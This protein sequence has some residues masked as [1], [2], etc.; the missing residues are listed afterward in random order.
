M[1]RL[2]TLLLA[3]LVLTAIAPAGAVGVTAQQNDCTFPVTLTDATGTEVTVDERPD[4]VTTL[5]P[6]AAQTMWEIGGKSQV[7]GVTE[8]ADYLD[9]A[10][11]RTSV[12]KT[13]GFGFSIERVIGTEPDIVLA[14]ATTAPDQVAT[15]RDAGLTVYLF[16]AATDTNDIAEKTTTIGRLTGNCEGAA[17]TNAWMT[18]NVEAAASVTDTRDTPSVL[19]PLGGGFVAN[20]NTFISAMIEASGGTNA[21][22]SVDVGE[23]Q[24]PQVSEEI[25]LQSDPEVLVVSS[26]SPSIA[27]QE[28]YASTTAGR[29]GESITV[30]ADYL[31]QPAPRSV[32][33]TV[34]TLT[35]AFHPSVDPPFVTRNSA[36]SASSE[37][38]ATAYRVADDTT[39]EFST[40]LYRGSELE[41]DGFVDEELVNIRLVTER[42]ATGVGSSTLVDQLQAG[43]DG[44][45]M[46]DTGELARSGNYIAVGQ[47][48]G[49]G[50]GFEVVTHTLNLS[51]DPTTVEESGAT[52]LGD[53]TVQSGESELA[54]DTN[55][56]GT[57]V[58]EVDS[59]TL[60][61]AELKRIFQQYEPTDEQLEAIGLS[62]TINGDYA[63]ADTDSYDADGQEAD[64]DDD[65][66]EQDGIAI[67]FEDEEDGELSFNEIDT[68]EYTFDV[69]HVATSAG[70][71]VNV[72]VA[73]RTDGE[74]N[75]DSSVYSTPQGDRVLLTAQLNR[76]DVATVQ[77]GEFSNVNYE[78]VAEIE[79]NGDGQVSFWYNTYEA[80]TDD[81]F[82]LTESSTNDGD[83][84]RWDAGA[85]PVGGD[86]TGAAPA[87]DSNTESYLAKSFAGGTLTTASYDLTLTIN[88][89]STDAG[90]LEVTER[91]TGES[92]T[93]TLAEEEAGTVADVEDL[94]TAAAEG[95]L[96]QDDTI[97][98]DQ[99][100]DGEVSTGDAVVHQIQVTGIYGAIET[101][102]ETGDAV[103]VTDLSN[104][105][106]ATGGEN[107]EGAG[108][109]LVLSQTDDTAEANADPLVLNLGASSDALTIIPDSENGSLYVIAEPGANLEFNRVSDSE[110]DDLTDGEAGNFDETVFD[111]DLVN[112]EYNDAFDVEFFIPEESGLASQDVSTT[113]SF[114]FVERDASFETNVDGE[115]A[116]APASEQTISGTTSIAAGSEITI[117]ARATGDNPFFKTADVTVGE[118]GDFSGTFDFSDTSN[119]TEFTVTI[120][121]EGF[122]DDAET[123]GVVSDAA[124][125]ETPTPTPE[126]ATDT[127]TSQRDRE[128]NTPTATPAPTTDT[129]VD[130]S[131]TATATETSG[132][133]PGFG[134]AVAI[135]ALVGAAL[136]ALRRNN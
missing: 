22:A 14:P 40:L 75:F 127:P 110:I 120:P 90:T 59:E 86:A 122:D 57:L 99:T 128:T 67:A 3:A 100:A 47:T 16:E 5:N 62:T 42:D 1:R 41:I 131:D 116:V 95:Y 130:G 63:D 108:A 133:Q 104:L 7:V 112:A 106:G 87:T 118:D 91:T 31:N 102:T 84:I 39:P 88:Q 64:D 17:R 38:P 21:L 55:R 46:L 60:D 109:E 8:F 15:L 37:S 77:I 73:E 119:M 85:S 97:A 25:I 11:E 96:T 43:G 48:T 23:T 56:A 10:S 80:T 70:D 129:P 72:T 125:M 132:S 111:G 51:V 2:L 30:N 121:S 126:P 117:R 92:Q 44:A 29:E 101:G 12:S 78:A 4:R 136:I 76:T 13:D 58:Y 45:A 18:A 93:W 49:N 6:S 82:V 28:P 65:P 69:S 66:V 32:V 35:T 115:I 105:L 34:Q 83:A 71:S 26:N 27:S 68:G 9:G 33:R 135:I 114:E 74:A 61:D 24:Y 52:A 79:D 94:H 124:Q 89:Y 98:V 20:T 54:I 113:S 19:Y 103:R 50:V 123:D 36:T 81:A 53:G 107:S 134:G